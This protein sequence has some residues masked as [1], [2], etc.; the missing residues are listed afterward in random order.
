MTG[1][2]AAWDQT[3]DYEEG[4][5]SDYDSLFPGWDHNADVE[6]LG[7]P[8]GDFEASG[9]SWDEY[10]NCEAGTPFG[11][12][13]VTDADGDFTR[14]T[15]A[16]HDGTY[17]MNVEFDDANVA[18]GTLNYVGVNQT[19][20][21]HSFWVNGNDI[22]ID[23]GKVV[24]FMRGYDGAGEIMHIYRFSKVSGVNK[25]QV[26]IRKDDTNYVTV[27]DAAFT[28][29][30]WHHVMVRHVRSTSGGAN[31]G[32]CYV[33]IDGTK[34]AT[35]TNI[36]NDTR[37]W[38]YTRWGMTLT[39]SVSFGGSMYLDEIYQNDALSQMANTLAK[40]RGS[41][42][43]LLPIN[44]DNSMSVSWTTPSGETFGVFECWFD[45][46]GIAMTSGDAFYMFYS[47]NTA[48]DRVQLGMEMNYNGSVY[49][50]RPAYD[51]D[52]GTRTFG[53]YHTITDAGHHIRQIWKASSGVG[54]NDGYQY[55]YIDGV[56]VDSITSIDSDLQTI[57][58]MNAAS[59]VGIDSGTDGIVYFDDLK[60]TDGLG[61]PEWVIPAAAI[62][63]SYGGAWTF[64]GD[65]LAT[66]SLL[67]DISGGVDSVSWEFDMDINSL[68][69]GTNQTFDIVS[70]VNVFNVAI[71]YTGSAYQ[72][73]FTI[74]NDAQQQFISAWYTFTDA[75]HTF[76]FV[77]GKSRAAGANNGFMAMFFDGVLQEAIDGIDNDGD[78]CD[79]IVFGPANQ[80]SSITGVLFVD[81]FR[82]V[83]FALNR[84]LVG[85]ITNTGTVGKLITLDALQALAGSITNTGAVL[86]TW[87]FDR[88]NNLAGS[89]TNTGTVGKFILLA[90]LQALAGNLTPTGVVSRIKVIYDQLYAW[91]SHFRASDSEDSL[92]A[93]SDEKRSRA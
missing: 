45:P 65:N 83:D 30:A 29:N 38:D 49:R 15:A 80:H 77:W 16:K 2:P 84:Y 26:F 60:F 5:D 47:T 17:G 7:N 4:D 85:S 55:T 18:Y 81:D 6:E 82:W 93:G 68:T 89:I 40:H 76:R 36:D 56:L 44:S 31:N 87:V 12:D 23:E 61:S 28:L 19:L 51:T 33:Y 41:Y 39:N 57:D 22:A 73:Q 25:F 66:F 3:A 24:D 35:V 46:N 70:L 88:T 43:L 11:F 62:S 75:P 1:E 32:R 86:F 50:L 20:F 71:R 91:T 8:P 67:T 34:V 59:G 92:R 53:S 52:A 63:G 21:A 14:I 10:N 54:A 72:M 58:I 78:S 74:R 37:D 9:G 69:I 48:L 42:G 13:S 79:Q 90:A 64:Y 27:Y